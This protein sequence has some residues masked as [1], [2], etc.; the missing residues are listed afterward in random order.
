VEEQTKEKRNRKEYWLH[1]GIVVKLVTKKLGDKYYKKKAV[2][3]VGHL[4]NRLD[5]NDS[6]MKLKIIICFGSRL[7]RKAV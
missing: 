6:T 3:K 2:V 5:L 1:A 4:Q 7:L